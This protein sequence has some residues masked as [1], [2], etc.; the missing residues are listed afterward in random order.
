M[1]S[2]RKAYDKD[3]LVLF[4]LQKAEMMHYATIQQRRFALKR[5]IINSVAST[6]SSAKKTKK[7]G[8]VVTL[9]AQ[10][11]RR[12]CTVGWVTF[13]EFEITVCGM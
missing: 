12:D 10:R 9:G 13:S 8:T 3:K 2:S 5:T 1:N 11:A 6:Q 4:F 7:L